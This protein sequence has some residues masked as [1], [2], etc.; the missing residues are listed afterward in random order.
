MCYKDMTFCTFFEKCKDRDKCGRALTPEIQKAAEE[1]WGSKDAPFC[2]FVEKPE[3][4][5]HE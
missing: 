3:C 1:W 5:K 2:T 4:F